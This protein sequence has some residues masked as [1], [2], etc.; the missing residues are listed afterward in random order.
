MKTV[1]SYTSFFLVLTLALACTSSVDTAIE[2]DPEV[3]VKAIED[4]MAKY[5]SGYES[6]DVDSFAAVFT[7]DAVRMPPNGLVVVG[8]DGIRK[9]YKD[10]FEKESLDVTVIPTEIQV[11]GNWAYAWGTYEATVTLAETGDT[12]ADRGKFLNIYRKDA[13]GAWR[14]HRNMW[15]SDLPVSVDQTEESR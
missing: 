8:G 9:Y 2:T 5:V 12:R 11:A 6:K 3:E 7:D 13:D 10:W 14:F 1:F 15:N 4:L